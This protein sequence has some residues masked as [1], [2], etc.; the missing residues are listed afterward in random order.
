MDGIGFA[1]R[2]I[3]RPETVPPVAQG[4]SPGSFEIRNIMQEM[5]NKASL[6]KE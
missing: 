2:I 6:G 4:F 5:V 3:N 1:Q